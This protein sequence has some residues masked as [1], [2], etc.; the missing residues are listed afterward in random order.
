MQDDVIAKAIH[1]P[2][3]NGKMSAATQIPSKD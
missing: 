1:H 2:I 3:G